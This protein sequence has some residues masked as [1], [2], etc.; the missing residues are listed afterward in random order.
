MATADAE[1]IFQRWAAAMG[2]KMGHDNIRVLDLFRQFDANGD[3][4]VSRAEFR[5]GI[6][7]AGVE[8]THEV[9]VSMTRL[10]VVMV[11]PRC[12]LYRWMFSPP[13]M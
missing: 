9:G 12:P 5:K 11:W 8:L 4:T 3:G 7:S 13:Y 1:A 6:A 2:D 10:G